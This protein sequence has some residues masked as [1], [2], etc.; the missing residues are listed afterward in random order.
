MFNGNGGMPRFIISNPKHLEVL[1]SHSGLGG[2][3]LPL[4]G[5]TSCLAK[6][7]STSLAISICTLISFISLRV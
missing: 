1:G 2:F 6:I 4:H 5:S 7:L 3:E